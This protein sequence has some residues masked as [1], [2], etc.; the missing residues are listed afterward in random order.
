MASRILV[1]VIEEQVRRTMYPR[2]YRAKVRQLVFNLKKYE[3]VDYVS[4]LSPGY[5]RRGRDKK[6]VE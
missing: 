3:R 6:V 5:I 2:E 1:G 4:L